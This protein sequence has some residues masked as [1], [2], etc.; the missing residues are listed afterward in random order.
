MVSYELGD[1]LKRASRGYQRPTLDYLDLYLQGRSP[2]LSIIRKLIADLDSSTFTKKVYL[3]VAA[4]P[5]SKTATYGEIARLIG[6]IGAAR[7]VGT[8]LKNNP[9]PLLIP[10]H[11]V[12]KSNGDI[13]YYNGPPGLKAKLLEFERA[14]AVK[15]PVGSRKIT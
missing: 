14:L 7:A 15:R 3:A 5:A 6:H 9:Y 12:I 1:L 11:R 8:A 10:C 13:G 2:D 4:I